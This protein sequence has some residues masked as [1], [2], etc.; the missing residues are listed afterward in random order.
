M[1]KIIKKGKI[2]IREKKK[3]CYECR[4]KFSYT[5]MDVEIDRDG[6]Y[7]KCPICKAFIAV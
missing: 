4:T 5:S 3:T 7:I 6:N 1:M 2:K